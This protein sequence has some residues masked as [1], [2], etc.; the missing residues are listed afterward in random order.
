MCFNG[1]DPFSSAWY[2]Q[3]WSHD[4]WR[5]GLD[6]PPGEPPVVPAE[7]WLLTAGWLRHG[8]IR[9]DELP[10]AARVLYPSREQWL[11][12]AV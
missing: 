8:R 1:I 5:R 9:P 7:T 10:A 6:P 2:F 12:M 4:R 11:G 3:G